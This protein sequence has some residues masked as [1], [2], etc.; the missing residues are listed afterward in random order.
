MW[1]GD[2]GITAIT[3]DDLECFAADVRAP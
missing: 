1:R 3:A 2:P